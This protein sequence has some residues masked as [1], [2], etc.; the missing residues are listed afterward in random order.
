MFF[1]KKNNP[2][3][4]NQLEL[5]AMPFQ[6]SRTPATAK[7]EPEKDFPK[8]KDT[9]LKYPS[10]EEFKTQLALLYESQANKK[11]VPP[12]LK[13]ILNHH[14]AAYESDFLH[15]SILADIKN[16]QRLPQSS[17]DEAFRGYLNSCLKGLI[18]FSDNLPDFY[19]R[20]PLSR[21]TTHVDDPTLFT[22]DKEEN[23]QYKTPQIKQ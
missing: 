3:P 17:S 20:Q 18:D 12:F 9:P 10:K 15:V 4:H 13:L 7:P 23:I 22:L 1:R 6:L 5:D 2:P 21:L 16:Y 8:P 14:G 11:L 19:I